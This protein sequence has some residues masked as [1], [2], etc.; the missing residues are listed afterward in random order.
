MKAD[1][2][3]GGIY[4]SVPLWMVGLIFVLALVGAGTIIA[5]VISL[6][7]ILSIVVCWIGWRITASQVGYLPDVEASTMSRIR[8]P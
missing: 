1:I 2:L 3:V 8:Q 7:E 5:W 6:P 4:Y